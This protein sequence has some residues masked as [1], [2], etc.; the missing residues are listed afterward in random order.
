MVTYPV[1]FILLALI[2]IDSAVWLI[3]EII[4]LEETFAPKSFL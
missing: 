3:Q 1:R 2:F 4:S